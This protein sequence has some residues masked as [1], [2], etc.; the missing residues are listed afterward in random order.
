MR[1]LIIEDQPNMASFL[2][3]GL[4]ENGFSVD[5]AQS[6]AAGESMAYENPYDLVILD[7]MLPDKNGMDVAR[8]LRS[9]GFGG[10]ILMLTALSRTKDK[11]SG[12]NAGA[13]DYLVKP[14]EFDELLAR[15]RALLRRNQVNALTKL[16]FADLEMDLVA[17]RVR[18]KDQDLT[19][20]PKEF[21]LLEYFLRHPGKAI[22]RTELSEHVWDMNYDPKSNVVDAYLSMLRKKV[23]EPFETKL[24]H[25][26][27]G[28][29]YVLRE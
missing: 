18:R 6:A 17:R 4:K 10:P 27:K 16:N 3:R 20:T 26:L 25:T 24:I 19:L 5:L 9:E 29:G 8:T 7:V 14:F 12:L 11:I 2:Q 23:D 21:S 22:T 15:V 1:L 13:D 28:F